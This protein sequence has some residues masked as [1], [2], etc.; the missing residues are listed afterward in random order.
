MTLLEKALQEPPS[1]KKTCFNDA[2]LASLSVAWASRALT[3]SQTL[4]ALGMK[5]NSASLYCHLAKGLRTAVDM[6]LLVKPK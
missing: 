3:A 5:T 6:G 4:T 2:E 1:K